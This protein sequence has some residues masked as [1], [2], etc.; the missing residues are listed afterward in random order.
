M[1]AV[2]IPEEGMGGGDLT[3]VGCF[4]ELIYIFFIYLYLYLLIYLSID[5]FID[6]FIYIDLSMVSF[7]WYECELKPPVMTVPKS[8]L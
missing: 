7:G 1:G 3:A 5:L 8:F 4:E 2:V 6:L